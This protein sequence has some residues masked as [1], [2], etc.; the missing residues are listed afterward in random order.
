VKI[1]DLNVL[2]Y[3]LNEDAQQHAPVL[4]WWDQALNGD[5][6][7]GLAWIVILGFLRLATQPRI[8]PRPLDSEQAIERISTWLSRPNVSVVQES[9]DH[10]RVLRE[11]LVE[12]GTAGNLTS[13]AHLAA[14]A[15]SRGATLVSCDSDFARF[16]GL[17][18]ESPLDA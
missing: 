1:V 10:W 14:L 5:E 3:A 6:P 12:S 9:D 7:I 13:D 17:R 11:L 8:F 2:L 16:R 18:R 15:V 4:R